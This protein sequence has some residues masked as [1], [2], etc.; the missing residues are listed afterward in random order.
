MHYLF[1]SL[2][3][4]KNT[5]EVVQD[6]IKDKK[7]IDIH[8]L[9]L[10]EFRICSLDKLLRMGD[11]LEQKDQKITKILLKI[12]NML[13]EEFGYH[14]KDLKKILLVN[15]KSIENYMNDLEW[16]ILKYAHNKTIE[17]CFKELFNEAS[18]LENKI[19]KQ[20]SFYN[21]QKGNYNK[22]KT[23]EETLF[24]KSLKIKNKTKNSENLITLCV[25]VPK[26][27]AKEFT[28]TYKTLSDFIVPSSLEL[29]EEDKENVLYTIT[30]FKRSVTTF[31]QNSVLKGIRI[32]PIPENININKKNLTEEIK[33]NKISLIKF[34]SINFGE[35]FCCLVHIKMIRL[36][37]ESILVYGLLSDNVSILIKTEEKNK[38]KIK[39][40][41]DLI[42][43]SIPISKKQ[44]IPNF[45]S[46]NEAEEENW[47][48]NCTLTFPI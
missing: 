5:K 16:N 1:V 13:K 6:E 43:Q 47:F 29:I 11:E 9:Y 23:K 27:K 7:R 31:K 42:L 36:Q 26:D 25:I 14:E 39:G 41:I 4:V 19:I 38:K 3:C 35:M 46:N 8:N 45:D 22:E 48:V 28:S 17:D 10:Q 20:I 44:K 32:R 12:I 37:I 34:L 40:K 15:G 30:L 21:D 24:T 18:I 2:P 33:K